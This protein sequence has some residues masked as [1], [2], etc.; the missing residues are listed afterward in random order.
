MTITALAVFLP[1]I[2]FRH[3]LNS[4][5]S[6]IED[7]VA[8]LTGVSRNPVVQSIHGIMGVLDS[9]KMFIASLAFGPV[10]FFVEVAHDSRLVGECRVTVIAAVHFDE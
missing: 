4:S 3:V 2:H 6:I 1:V 8:G 7:F 10:I 9:S 5:S